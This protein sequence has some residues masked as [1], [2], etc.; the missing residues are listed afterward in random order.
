[1]PVGSRTSQA[2]GAVLLLG[3]SGRYGSSVARLLA[4]MPE[5]TRLVIAGRD[6]VAARD[7]AATLGRKA[8]AAHLDLSHAGELSDIAAAVELVILAAGPE[9]LVVLPALRGAIAAGAHYC[10]LC[11]D[12]RV[13]VEAR[14]LDGKAK[15]AGIIALLGAGVSPGLSNLTMLR[16]AKRSTSFTTSATASC[17]SPPSATRR[18]PSGY[19]AGVSRGTSTPPG[20]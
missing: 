12:A 18:R 8:V 16:A 17:A 20:S 19:D 15:D 3:G 7:V 10:D 6:L 1:M 5:V 14:R 2:S 13:V 11:A 4:A 9:R